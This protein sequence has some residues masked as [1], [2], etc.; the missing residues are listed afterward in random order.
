MP[1]TADLDKL[2]D[3][4]FE[5]S[6]L[7]EILAAPVSALAGLTDAHAETLQ[8]VFKIRSIRDLGRN[9]FFRAA[10]AMVVLAEGAGK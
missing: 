9:K 1:V 7:A 4:A 3:K 10:Q 5:Q 8:Q 2:L 6:D